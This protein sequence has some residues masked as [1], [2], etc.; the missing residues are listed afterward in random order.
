MLRTETLQRNH[1]TR[2]RL[3]GRTTQKFP[4]PQPKA[5]ASLILHTYDRTFQLFAAARHKRLQS[6]AI[7][8]RLHP[9]GALSVSAIRHK[10]A[11]A[12]LA[13]AA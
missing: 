7:R 1:N 4:A 6:H 12:L 9:K 3:I 13:A 8:W 11:E 2:M 5:L 10:L